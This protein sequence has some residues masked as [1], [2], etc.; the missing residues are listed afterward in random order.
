MT[1]LTVADLKHLKHQGEKIVSLACHTYPV[2]KIADPL[3]EVILVGDSVGMVLYGMES[4]RDVSIEM[5]I[6]H[7]KAV[8]KATNKAFIIVDMPFGTYESSKEIALSNAQ[9]IIHETNAQAVKLEGGKE[10]AETIEYLVK[11]NINVA[12]HI[13]LLP[14]AYTNRK[15]FRIQGKNKESQV[16]LTEDIIAVTNAGAFSVVIEG[17]TKE[18]ADKICG[19]TNSITIGIGAGDGCDGQILVIDDIIG[20]SDY[21]PKFARVYENSSQLINKAVS[22][23]SKDVKSGKFPSEENIYRT[24]KE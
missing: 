8:C 14:Q 16:Q 7:G 2:A 6:A 10:R 12:A 5:I 23:Y 22:H 24:K 1:R 9:K 19:H 11:H 21:I 20:T 17:V 4:T 18:T 15:D 13:G 3:C